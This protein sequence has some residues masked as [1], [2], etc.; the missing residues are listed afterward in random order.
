MEVKTSA[1]P[2]AVFLK[3]TFLHHLNR[4]YNA[5]C[6]LREHTPR[7]VGLASFTDLQSAV[8]E[9]GGDVKKQLERMET[10][11]KLIGETPSPQICNPIKSIIKDEFY[12]EEGQNIPLLNDLDL[13]LYLQLLEHINIT[14]YRMLIMIA[15]ILKYNE[16]KQLLT[17][18]FDESED[19]DLLFTLIAKE[20]LKAN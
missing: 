10:I 14:S 16:I 7:L 4:I 2:D 6:L 9:F 13:V 20:Y 12:L 15:K 1:A 3:Q 18:N 8:K 11:Y 17:E 5:K 19:N